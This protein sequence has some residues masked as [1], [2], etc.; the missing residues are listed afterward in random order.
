MSI[1][2]RKIHRTLDMVPRLGC[3]EPESTNNFKHLGCRLRLLHSPYLSV[4]KERPPRLIRRYCNLWPFRSRSESTNKDTSA[5]NRLHRED[6]YR[7][8]QRSQTLT[9]RGSGLPPD[10][11]QLNSPLMTLSQ[12]L[13]TLSWYRC[14]CCL[15]HCGSSSYCRRLYLWKCLLISDEKRGVSKTYELARLIVNAECSSPVDFSSHMSLFFLSFSRTAREATVLPRAPD[16]PFVPWLTLPSPWASRQ[17]S[18][19]G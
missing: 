8:P 17:V 4:K 7:C 19:F 1:R 18:E 9:E 13:K 3:S 12:L 15:G 2:P 5:L 6:R 10:L 14:I 11:S 16:E